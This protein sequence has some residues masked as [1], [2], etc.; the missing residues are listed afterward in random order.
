M[1]DLTYVRENIDQVRAALQARRA[2]TTALDDFTRADEERRRAIAESDQLNAQRNSAS[3]EIG[4]LMKDGKKDE[5]E[6]RRGQVA[7]LKNQI[8]ELDQL[9]AATETRMHDLLSTLPNIPHETVPVGEDES[10]NVE[11]RR[12]GSAPKFSFEPLDHVDLATALGI[13]DLERATKIASARFAI[14]NG[15]GARLERALVNFM[16]DVQT[17]EHGYLETLPP[18]IVNRA[19]LFGTAQLP[20]FEADLFK[21]E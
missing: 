17:R 5:A 18:F 6:K 11:V 13:L 16:L 21:L 7:Q 2:D 4:A 10:A 12:W 9:R 15:A 20:K 19:A 3:R 1:L 8:G 14:L